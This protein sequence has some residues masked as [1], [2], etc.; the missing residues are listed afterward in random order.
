MNTDKKTTV[1]GVLLAIGMA[2]VTFL[3]AGF[4]LSNPGWWAGMV[5]AGAAGA[6][7]YWTNK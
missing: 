4:D 1:S 2:M 3:Q 5:A 6:Q 7:G